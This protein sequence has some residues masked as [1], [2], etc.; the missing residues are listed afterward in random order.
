MLQKWMKTL[1]LGLILGFAVAV[2]GYF[3]MSHFHEGHLQIVK[4]TPTLPV[5]NAHMLAH[6]YQHPIHFERNDGQVDAQVKYLTRGPGYTFYFTPQEI[7]TVFSG[8]SGESE[9]HTK[10]SVALKLKFLGSNPEAILSGTQKLESISNYFIGND[11]SQWRT[12]I[13][14]YAKVTYRNLYEGIDA[15]F[16][17]NPQQ[18]EYDLLVGPGADPQNIRLQIEGAK[19]LVLDSSGNLEILTDAMQKVVMQKPLVYQLFGEEKRAIEGDYVLAANQEVGFRV[20]GYDTTKLL[21]IDPIVYSTF[22]GSF[23]GGNGIA[24]DDAGNAYVTGFAV[25]SAFPTTTGV[26]QPSFGGSGDAFVTKLNSTGTALVYS[27]FLG[28]S[29]FDQGNGIAVDSGGNVYATGFTT[30]SDFPTTTG[31]FQSAIEGFENAFVTKLNP[32]GTSLIYST[33]LGGGTGLNGDQGNGI[34]VDGTGNAYV[35]GNTTSVDFPTTA[36]AFQTVLNGGEANAFVTQLN[37]SGTGLI[38][39]T[40]LGGSSNRNSGAGIAVDGSGNAYVTG[41]TDSTDFPT[42]AGAFQTASGVATRAYVTKFNPAG[43]ALLYS[44]YLGASTGGTLGFGIAIDSSRNAY[45]TG[46]TS[47]SNFP[48]T[49]GVVQPT[50]GGGSGCLRDSI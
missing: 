35:A 27:T 32:A 10:T 37:S 49:A 48:T 20:A 34:A 41:A 13:P 42:T 30:S 11:S 25:S 22:L 31:V 15:A 23:S 46:F 21:V 18:L 16:Y 33:Y 9:E 5:N 12:H 17:G 47:A 1:G 45:V 6:F 8:E 36:G 40:Y 4:G 2:V 43:T 26:V 39:S 38:Y 19:E 24:A 44:T 28:G 29:G 14:N 50:L 3:S 7:I